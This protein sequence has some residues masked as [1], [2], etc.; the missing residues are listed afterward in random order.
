MYVYIASLAGSLA[1][2]GTGAQPTNLGVQWAIRII[3]FIA[4]VAV[5]IYV[6]RVARKALAEAVPNPD[7]KGKIHV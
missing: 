5:T 2:L 1:T 6:T 7:R 4:T 3:G